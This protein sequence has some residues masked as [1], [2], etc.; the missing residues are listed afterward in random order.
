MTKVQRHIIKVYRRIIKETSFM[1]EVQRRRA[2][3]MCSGAKGHRSRANDDRSKAK[4]VRLKPN[5]LLI[6]SLSAASSLN[7]PKA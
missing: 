3:P 6:P 2:K 4:R 1:T 7:T 5:P